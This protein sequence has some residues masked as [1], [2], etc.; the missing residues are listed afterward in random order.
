MY[1][2]TD[3]KSLI[4]INKIYTVHYFEYS[5]DFVF[6]KERHDF[7]ELVY[8]E[9]GEVRILMDDEEIILG[10]GDLAFFTPNMWHKVETANRTTP[11]VMIL[12]FEC[13][14]EAMSFFDKGLFKID[15]KERGMLAALLV[16]A[17]HLFTCPL[18][19][20]YTKKM[21]VDE[22]ALVGSEQ[23][24]KLYLE[25]F[26][27]HLLRRYS[28]PSVKSSMSKIDNSSEQLKII[29]NY[30]EENIYSKLSI[31]QI[32]DDNLINRMQLQNLFNKEMNESP[33]E[34]FINLKISYAKKLIRTGKM[35]FNQISEKLGYNTVHYFSKQFK[36][37]SGMTPTDYAQSIKAMSERE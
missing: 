23:L 22:E 18:N 37:V 34:Y 2:G 1:I 8:V 10:K 32:C 29:I 31:K 7:W 17:R 11:N 33:M 12:S 19:D 20:P 27:I 3:L 14:D 28:L 25:A 13:R 4:T 36:K 15:D 35:N 16:E 26:L 5:T 9:S 30:M 24:I 21:E 6:E